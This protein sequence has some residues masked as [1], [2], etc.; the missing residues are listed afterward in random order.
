M[1]SNDTV[2]IKWDKQLLRNLE[3]LSWF[4]DIVID[5][6]RKTIKF[7]SKTEV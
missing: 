3:F 7:L 2:E 1:E 6:D 5:G 4:F